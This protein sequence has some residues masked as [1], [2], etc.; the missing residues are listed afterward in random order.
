M[1]EIKPHYEK[2]IFV[3]TNKRDNGEVCCADKGS[4]ELHKKMKAYV[5]EQGLSDTIRVSKSGCQ[6]L[7]SSGITVSV[8]PDNKVY[9]RVTEEDIITIVEEAKK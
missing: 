1:K 3:C 4:C 2:I 6:D 8:Y 7:C 5:K 9:G